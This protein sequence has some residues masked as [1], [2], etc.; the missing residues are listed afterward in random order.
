MH[1]L[2]DKKDIEKYLNVNGVDVTEKRL[3]ANSTNLY[4]STVGKDNHANYFKFL[5]KVNKE[6]IAF[7]PVHETQIT[8]VIERLLNKKNT[9]LD[10]I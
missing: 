3:I 9:G 2:N 5:T 4:F 7:D 1:R 6:M 8:K 10:N